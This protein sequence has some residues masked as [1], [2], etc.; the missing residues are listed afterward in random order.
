M[1]TSWIR[2]ENN[3]NVFNSL[4]KRVLRIFLDNETYFYGDYSLDIFL[5]PKNSIFIHDPQ[6]DAIDETIKK[7]KQKYT[8][9]FR[10]VNAEAGIEMNNAEYNTLD[11][12][13]AKFG[14]VSS[15]SIKKM[16]PKRENRMVVRSKVYRDDGNFQ[17]YGSE[18]EFFYY[19]MC[20][21]TS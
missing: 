14:N 4:N 9:W 21:A 5:I 6:I 20:F 3:Q 7:F 18:T 12:L 11:K 8:G 10:N 16:F 17:I 13:I 2:I 1:V 19:I 15:K